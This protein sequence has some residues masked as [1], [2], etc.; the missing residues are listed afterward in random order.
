VVARSLFG[1]QYAEIAKQAE[2]A[3]DPEEIL[4]ITASISRVILD[5]QREEIGLMRGVS[6]LSP[7]LKAIET[8]LR[9]SASR[10]R[11]RAPSFSSNPS[12]PRATSASPAYATSYGCI[13]AATSIA[14]SCW[15]GPDKLYDPISPPHPGELSMILFTNVILACRPAAIRLTLS[16]Y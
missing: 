2:K 4:H 6:A 9:P 10:F 1:A 14:C 5:T 3:K 11:K 15:S 12:P 16:E 8:E 7:E 13:P